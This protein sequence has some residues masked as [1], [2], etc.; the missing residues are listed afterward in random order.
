MNTPAAAEMRLDRPSVGSAVCGGGDDFVRASDMN[1]SS[2]SP[3]PTAKVAERG[4]TRSAS[5]SCDPVSAI[6]V[7]AL[8]RALAGRARRLGA[9]ERGPLKSGAISPA[10]I[11]SSDAPVAAGIRGAIRR[12]SGIDQRAT[13]P[14]SAT[15]T[16]IVA[17]CAAKL[18]P[19]SSAI[20]DHGR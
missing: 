4:T 8:K 2:E 18:T 7:A 10:R 17:A 15:T 3:A 5:G 13:R 12:V 16:P 6:H 1:P 20:R 9:S 11:A 14:H 19:T